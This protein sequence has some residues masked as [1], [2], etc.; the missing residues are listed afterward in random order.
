MV[1]SHTVLHPQNV[2]VGSAVHP[3][4]TRAGGHIDERDALTGARGFYTLLRDFDYAKYTNKRVYVV[5]CDLDN[6]RDYNDAYGENQCNIVLARVGRTLQQHFGDEHTYRYGSDE[7]LVVDA[8]ENNEALERE[9]VKLRSLLE[10]IDIDGTPLGMTCSCG[11]AYGT[12]D[13]SEKLHEAI[14]LADLKVLEA[15]RKGKNRWASASLDEDPALSGNW[16][17]TNTLKSYESD[18]LTGLANLICFRRKLKDLMKEQNAKSDVPEDDRLALLYLN[19]ENFKHYNQQF[20]FD[21]GDRLLLL[22]SEAIRETFPGCTASRFSGDQFMVVT[23]AGNAEQGFVHVR[24]SFRNK[25]KDT[26]IWLRSGGYVPLAEEEDVGAAMDRAKMACDNIKG[27][28]DRFFCLYDNVLQMQINTH[29]YVLDSFDQALEDDWIRPYYQPIARVCTSDICDVEALSRWVDPVRG[30]ISPAEFIPVLEDARL[31]HK[32]DLKIVRDV[33]RDYRRITDAG[34]HLVAPSVN[35][36]RLDFEL[37]DIVAE[38]TAIADE[39]QVPHKYL[40]VEI[41]ESAFTDSQEFLKDEIDRFRNAG[42]QV[43]MDDFGSGYSSLNL[44]KEYQFDLIKLDMAFL[45][46]FEVNESSRVILSHIIGMAKEL[47][48]KTLVEGVETEEQYH[49]LRSIGCGRAQGWHLGRPN[50]L[51]SV[52]S[53]IGDDKK[54]SFEQHSMH[55]FYEEVGKVNLMRPK[56]APAVDGHV[57]TGDTPAAIVERRCGTYHYLNLNDT[58][59]RFLYTMGVNSVEENE[60]LINSDIV[61]YDRLKE[62]FE[63]SV[64]SGGWQYTTYDDL[65]HDCAMATKCIAANREEDAYAFLIVTADSPMLDF[66]NAGK[67]AEN[68][69]AMGL[70]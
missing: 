39:Y 42:F 22:I 63:Q 4:E 21:E 41:T 29:R 31:I 17:R 10:A 11:Y 27:R 55:S 38:I 16:H 13:T 28:R 69:A 32:L 65:G 54:H 20:G 15:K 43:W 66:N 33:C 50:T 24:N 47:E 70:S 68:R 23:T 60:R 67:S 1:T 57:A 19:V 26:S 58:Y 3:Q 30:L 64:A 49:F 51:E 59:R 25:R 37:C 44:L 7:F 14:R 5:L 34:G 35:L 61:H 45:R 2:T 48:F 6:F 56:P 53:S 36:S 18:E 12:V 40:A 46:N 8:F 62:S 52:M 9:L